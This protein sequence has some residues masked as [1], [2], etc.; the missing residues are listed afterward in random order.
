MS[1][2]VTNAS[3]EVSMK[4]PSN[5]SCGANAIE[6]TRMSSPPASVDGGEGALDARVV[7]DVA[8]DHDVRADLAA[9]LRTD[10]SS[11]SPW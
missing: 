4:R 8:L 1:R 3:R 9:S 11:R 10:S 7:G 5:D 2:A 6:W